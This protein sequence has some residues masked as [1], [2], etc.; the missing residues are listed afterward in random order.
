M[1]F[2][3]ACWD[4]M[5]NN[6]IR[7]VNEFYANPL[8]PKVLIASFLGLIPK[9]VN[10]QSREEYKPICLVG[11]LFIILSKLLASR[12]KKVMSNMISSCQNA[13]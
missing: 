3:K 12:L 1:R 6:I 13:F 4:I 11:S 9:S 7:F 10:P 5:K 2:F 8:L